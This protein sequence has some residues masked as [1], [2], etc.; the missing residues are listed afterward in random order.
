[1]AQTSTITLESLAPITSNRETSLS[2]NAPDSQTVQ[3]HQQ[4]DEQPVADGRGDLS[5]GRTIAIIATLTGTT[6]V[7]SFS[8][9]LLTVGLPKMAADLGLPANLLLW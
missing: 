3:S 9:G 7:S 6:I 5:R 1:M 2:I 4:Q 8:S